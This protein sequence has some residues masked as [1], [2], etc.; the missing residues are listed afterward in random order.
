ME[1][2]LP[3][4][5]ALRR[6]L[7]DFA[8]GA[9][10]PLEARARRDVFGGREFRDLEWQV[11]MRV[12]GRTIVAAAVHRAAMVAIELDGA[13]FHDDDA[14]RRADRLRDVE[15]AAAGWV[16]LRFG[17]REVTERPKWCRERVRRVLAARSGGGLG[18]AAT[19]E[20]MRARLPR[21]PGGHR[22]G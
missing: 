18:R 10:S 4:R 11:R 20:D 6:L 15:L 21:E 9:T 7:A 13:R 8:D 5:R 1:P 16:T 2:R 22:A 19:A 14:A 3:H 17:W 12:G